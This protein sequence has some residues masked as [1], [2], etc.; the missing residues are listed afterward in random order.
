MLF[1]K[2]VKVDDV[3]ISQSVCKYLV[4]VGL[5]LHIAVAFFSALVWAAI[6]HLS[7]TFSQVFPCLNRIYL[8][9]VHKHQ[10]SPRCNYLSMCIHPLWHL[11]RNMCLQDS[12][13]GAEDFCSSF[14]CSEWLLRAIYYMLVPKTDGFTGGDRKHQFEELHAPGHA[15]YQ[16]LKK[17]ILVFTLRFHQQLYGLKWTRT[18]FLV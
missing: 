5:F 4:D 16:S 18:V 3:L 6:R 1:E 8:A 17:H 10:L 11:C 9:H 12:L 15:W 13:H 14:N 7:F 2:V